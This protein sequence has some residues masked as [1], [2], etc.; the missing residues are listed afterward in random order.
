MSTGSYA[1]TLRAIGQALETARLDTFQLENVGED[2][3]V[4]GETLVQVQSAPQNWQPTS[5]WQKLKG[6]TPPSMETPAVQLVRQPVQLNYSSSDI[7]RLEQEGQ[8]RRRNP[9]GMPETNSP[10]QVLRAAGAYLDRKRAKLQ[11][12]SKLDGIIKVRYDTALGSTSEELTVSYL[13]D[14][15]VRL[16]M[17]RSDRAREEAVG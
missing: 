9:H 13:Y 12:L 8:S 1:Q 17:R 16:Y 15:A 11:E 4:R 10:S 5:I 3:Y 7:E 6:S 14:M 2:Y